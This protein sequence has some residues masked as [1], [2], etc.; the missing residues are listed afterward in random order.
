MALKAVDTLNFEEALGEL[1]TI[2]RTLETGEAALENSISAYER[3]ML[4]KKHCENKLNDA[5]AKI[6]K[7]AV[8]KD[9]SIKIQ[10]LDSEE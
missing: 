8:A 7:I 5:K 6:E 3:G 4:L 2:V 9:G 10:P 1:Q